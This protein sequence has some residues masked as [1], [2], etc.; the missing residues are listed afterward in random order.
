MKQWGKFPVYGLQ[1]AR[2]GYKKIF[3][4]KTQLEKFEHDI[5]LEEKTGVGRDGKPKYKPKIV[6]FTRFYL[7]CNNCGV[8]IVIADR[9]LDKDENDWIMGKYV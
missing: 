9:R 7:P 8:N 4:D 1:C 3:T 2:C 5:E 6:K